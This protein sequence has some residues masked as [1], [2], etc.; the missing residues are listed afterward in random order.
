[1]TFE[2]IILT[3]GIIVG[4]FVIV[5]ALVVHKANE[6]WYIFPLIFS[7]ILLV[8]SIL[9]WIGLGWNALVSSFM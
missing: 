7:I 9:G 4:I 1:M 5:I 3:L 8:V 2:I 6:D